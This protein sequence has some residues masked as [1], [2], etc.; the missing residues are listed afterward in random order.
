MTAQ[1]ISAVPVPFTLDGEVDLTEF[2]A[3]LK[4]IDEHVN[5][6][7]V[8]G[9]TG[10]FPALDDEERVDLLRRAVAVLGA[11]RV[12][13]HLGHA[14]SRQVLRLA[15]ATVAEGVS[16]FALM[17]PYFLPTDDDG[18]VEH[19]RRLTEAFPA[20]TV[21]AYLFPE[22]TGMDVSVDVLRRVLE[23]PGMAG[24][25]LSGGAAARLVEYARV[26][27]P[28][29]ELYSGDDSTLPWVLEQGG[30]GIVSGVSA[31]F[32]HTFAA[33]ARALDAGDPSAVA[34]AQAIVVQVVGLVG[35]TIPR[36]KTALA[37]RT[38]APWSSRMAMPAV[39]ADLKTQ[40]EGLVAAH[41]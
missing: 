17:S 40:I 13:A 34:E 1:I 6:V 35:P 12:I 2:E 9:T 36:L 39:S 30:A 25:K 27:G 16:R 29:Q 4:S 31:A 37:A 21:Y 19:Y 15:A 20:A 33:L 22:R 38:G 14:S 18:V 32:P 11:E 8:G 24:V 5:G 28:R 7:L 10:E 3:T 41:A 23:L 26:V